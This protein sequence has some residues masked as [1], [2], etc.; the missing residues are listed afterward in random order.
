MIRDNEVIELQN[1]MELIKM[2][3]ENFSVKLVGGLDTCIFSDEWL[4]KYILG[5]D[6]YEGYTKGGFK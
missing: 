3:K 4:I 5:E 1:K 6:F 2:I